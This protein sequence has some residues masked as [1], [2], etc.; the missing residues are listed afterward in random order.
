MQ[1]LMMRE[2]ACAEEQTFV[3]DYNEYVRR[4][5]ANYSESYIRKAWKVVEQTFDFFKAKAVIWIQNSSICVSNRWVRLITPKAERAEGIEWQCEPIFRD[6]QQLYLIELLNARDEL[7]WS[8]VGTTTRSTPK[9]M[10]EHLRYYAKYGITK[11]RVLRVWECDTNA[12]AYES[13]FRFHYIKT[14]PNTF[15]KN[16][17]FCQVRFD[18]E[19]AD[20]LIERFKNWR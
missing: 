9:R 4:V 1:E 7:I 20:K 18:L 12:E 6:C 11:I 3:R 16:D 14:H 19:E 2:T 5:N 10:N 8:K 17:R 13:A 15:Q